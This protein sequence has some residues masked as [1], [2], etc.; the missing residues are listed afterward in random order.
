MAL[1]VVGFEA[2]L[3]DKPTLDELCKH[4]RI[5]AKWYKFGVLLKLD[6]T[7]LEGIR[8]MNEDSVF[9]TV[10]MFELWLKSNPIATRREIMEILKIEAISEIT[11]AE[12]YNKALKESESY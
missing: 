4:V 6:T 10:K 5:D 9:K 2:F 1:K 11:F 7:N 12:E 3:N 8:V